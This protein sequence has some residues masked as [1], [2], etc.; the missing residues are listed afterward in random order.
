MIFVRKSARADLH[1]ILWG[2]LGGP[3]RVLSIGHA[4]HA[5]PGLQMSRATSPT[6]RRGEAFGRVAGR[7]L[8]KRGRRLVFLGVNERETAKLLHSLPVLPA[9]GRRLAAYTAP[10]RHALCCLTE[11]RSC[12]RVRS[13][14][15]CCRPAFSKTT[16][17]AALSAAK[18]A[19]SCQGTVCLSADREHHPAVSIHILTF[20]PLM[21]SETAGELDHLKLYTQFLEAAIWCLG[22]LKPNVLP[23]PS[24]LLKII[25]PP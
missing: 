15:L 3:V 11:T 14:R 6:G 18:M 21:H 13:S 23:F 24:V 20:C 4:Q 10:A 19:I 7:H 9:T 17:V 1:I 8:G 5:V 16:S 22:K 25:A 2:R 12:C